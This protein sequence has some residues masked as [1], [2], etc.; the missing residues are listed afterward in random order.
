MNV[1]SQ[2]I[3]HSVCTKVITNGLHWFLSTHPSIYNMN[4]PNYYKRPVAVKNPQVLDV[5]I[6]YFSANNAL[7]KS[8]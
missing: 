6:S 3:E 7:H 8:F 2:N 5:F 4:H 1:N